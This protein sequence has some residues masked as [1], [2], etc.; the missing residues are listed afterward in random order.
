MLNGFP[1]KLDHL[2]IRRIHLWSGALQR[3]ADDLRGIEGHAEEHPGNLGYLA[4]LLVRGAPAGHRRRGANADDVVAAE[5]VAATADEQRH[6]G[7]LAPAVGVQLVENE[8]TQSVRGPDQLAI[9]AAREQQFQH[10]VVRQQDVGRMAAN[11]VA[12]RPFF[13]ARVA[14]E[15]DRGLTFRISLLQELARLLVLAVGQGVH[16]IH[17]DCLDAPV[18]TAAQDMVHDGHDVGEALA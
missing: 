11:C 3:L 10:H 5:G 7:P 4:F 1:Q 15:A 6:V 16:R 12:F 18:R 14:G 2:W 17:H 13:L 8:K 9:L